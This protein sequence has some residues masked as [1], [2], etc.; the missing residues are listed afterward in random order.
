MKR[1]FQL[2]FIVWLTSVFFTSV[3]AEMMI[4][5]FSDS[6]NNKAFWKLTDN[7]AAPPLWT[8][9]WDGSEVDST[10]Y[11]NLSQ[12]DDVRCNI[13]S[14]ANNLEPWIRF[15]FTINQHKNDIQW[16]YVKM[17][18]IRSGGTNEFCAVIQANFT[19]SVWFKFAG[20]ITATASPDEIKSINYTTPI[21]I[22]RIIGPNQQLV[23]LAEGINSD[24]QEGCRLDFVEVRVGYAST[25]PNFFNNG[26]N[27]SSGA[28]ILKGDGIKIFSQWNENV[29]LNY[30]WY[31]S[32]HSGSW[33]NYSFTPYESAGFTSPG[34]WSNFTIDTSSFSKDMTF[35][36]RIFANDTN[37]NQNTTDYWFWTIPKDNIEIY[38][39]NQTNDQ[40]GNVKITNASGIL[41]SGNG[42]VSVFLDLNKNYT[43][44]ISDYIATELLAAIIS[45][46]NISDSVN[47][48][49]QIVKSY[50]GS[51]PGGIADVT[52]IFA[53][54]DTN[55]NYSYAT[56]YIPKEGKRIN[57]ILHCLNWDYSTAT[58]NKWEINSTYDYNIQ[59]NATH[60]WFN[61]TDFD[62]FGGGSTS[63]LEVNLVLPPLSFSVGQNQTFDVNA[64]VFCRGG[65]C[66]NVTG[67]VRYNGSSI[68]PDTLVNTTIGDKPF[69]VQESPS[70][71]IK[72]C[73]TNP[74]NDSDEFCNITWKIN[75]TGD[76]NSEWKIG[77]LFNA[78]SVLIEENH[79]SN[80]TINIFECIVDISL[81]WSSITFPDLLPSRNANPASENDNNL[82][83]VTVNP[84]SCV[85]NLWIKGSDL[86]N[87]TLG[88]KIGVGNLTW[89]TV[90]VY[91]TSNRMTKDF[92]LLQSNVQAN[93]NITTYYW[94]DVPSIYA[95]RYNGNI[96]I[97]GNL[98][99]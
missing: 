6:T 35:F 42:N 20:D 14:G 54:N 3:K 15:N 33:Q 84:G 68:N 98:T 5:N 22:Q 45:D 95:G 43:I 97:L 93:N 16:V 47:I 77:V 27:I 74:L 86:E 38:L 9:G 28:T 79:T 76:I 56:L 12:S 58:C 31:E 8:N 29:K 18:G 81:G 50:A 91:S 19:N 39:F 89:N 53:L 23:L 1:I 32:N 40:T 10:C 41:G 64:T 26:T 48:T 96:T 49:S 37:N 73:P 57:R 4:Y 25:P 30:T 67:I 17:E 44:E 87:T 66:D 36:V 59:E 7:I 11:T 51:L 69:Y 99:S 80:S 70:L 85:L 82:Y 94:L 75:A 46:F 92:A 61:V 88:T 60:I 72:E 2:I 34:N 83:N 63:Y 21:E 13:L 78:S 90:N 65:G 55:L 71:A 24:N 62:G 52:S